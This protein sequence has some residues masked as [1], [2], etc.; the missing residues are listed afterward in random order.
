MSGVGRRAG[1]RSRSSSKSS[2]KVPY[3]GVPCA[4]AIANGMLPKEPPG[5]WVDPDAPR[6]IR[7]IAAPIEAALGWPGLGD[8]LAAIA[9]KESRG[10]SQAGSSG[11]NNKARGWFG[12]RP[13]SAKLAERGLPVS[14]LKDERKSVALAADYAYRMKK[15]GA[16]DQVVDWLAVDRGWANYWRVPDIYDP[17]YCNQLA[18]G[19]VAAGLQPDFMLKPAFSPGF[20]WPGFDT[21]LEIAEAGAIA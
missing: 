8:Y 9:W 11:N 19:L 1:R 15:Y 21:V 12:V 5:P 13:K 4:E 6:R 18:R 17:G 20:S 16:P 14:V 3:P 2:G 10:S 7:L